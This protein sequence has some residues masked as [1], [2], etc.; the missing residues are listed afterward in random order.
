MAMARSISA[1]YSSMLGDTELNSRSADAQV[2]SNSPRQAKPHPAATGES[3]EYTT[4]NSDCSGKTRAI[5]SNQTRGSTGVPRSRML[6]A[7]TS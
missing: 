2:I 4:A 7:N 1:Q 3:P 5:R 6:R